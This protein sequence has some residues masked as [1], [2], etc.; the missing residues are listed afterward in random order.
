MNTI[1]VLHVIETLESGGAEGLLVRI[2]KN[3]DKN[4][5]SPK[6]VCL[7]NRM[8]LKDELDK[9]GIAVFCIYMKN[10]YEWWKA[11]ISLYKLIKR[12]KIDIIHTHLFFANIYGRIAAK[13]GGVK[14]IITTLHNPDYT[15]EDNGKWTYKF[16]KFIDKYTGRICNDYFVAVSNFVKKDFEKNMGFKN[17]NVIYNCIDLS[18]FIQKDRVLSNNKRGEFGFKE[19]D[20]ILLN[21]GR[22]HRQKGQLCLIEAFKLV[23]TH[24]DMCRLIIIGKGNMESELKNKVKESGLKDKVMFIKDRD[25]IPDIMNACDIFIF[26]SMYEGFGIALIEA[27]ASG[28]AVIASDIETLREIIDN[29]S[30]GVLI[31]KE[32]HIKLAEAIFK[33][34]KND[35]FRFSLGNTARKMAFEKF[36]L[37]RYVEKLEALYI[38]KALA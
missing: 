13:L 31:E 12:E 35:N 32:N 19:D 10:P 18:K 22:L 14:S 30:N 2:L 9:A 38:K 33:L 26:P 36:N 17:I 5:F 20:M 7:F 1:G 27:M 23:S 37:E 28:L 29:N 4:K 8:D 6:V 3:I 11:I 21:I 15:Y 25:D 34:I 16:R 24:N